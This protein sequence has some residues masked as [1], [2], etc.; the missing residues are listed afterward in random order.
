MVLLCE[1]YPFSQENRYTRANCPGGKQQLS[2]FLTPKRDDTIEYNEWLSGLLDLYKYRI[3]VISERLN[4]M[5]VKTK[6]DEYEYYHLKYQ[7]VAF[8][9]SFDELQSR[10]KDVVE[11]NS[12]ISLAQSDSNVTE[13]IK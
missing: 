11:R 4:S 13:N 10:E 7:L 9:E 5:P 6:A 8:Q 12:I 3:N 1:S 2:T